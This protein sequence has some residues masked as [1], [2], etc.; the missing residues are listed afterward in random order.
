MK[1]RQ[2]TFR[3]RLQTN[4]SKD[5]PRSQKKDEDYARNVYQKLKQKNKQ[6]EMNNTLE[7]VNSRI[8]KSE[9]WISDLEDRMV[10]IT[11]AKQNTKKRM[12]RNE[13][14]VR[15]P[16]DIKHTNIHIIGVPEREEREKGYKKIFEKNISRKNLSQGSEILLC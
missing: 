12:K 8:T 10:E 7:A 6:T 9:K 16:W 5:D 13:G 14:S 11:A 3:K 15:N 2:A 4:N 1:W